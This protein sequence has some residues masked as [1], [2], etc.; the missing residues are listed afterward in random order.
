V[1][2]STFQ[3]IPGIGVKTERELWAKGTH[4]WND[5]LNS[6]KFPSNNKY[7]R[8][9]AGILESKG[10]LNEQDHQYFR[11]ILKPAITWRAYNEFKDDAC[12]VD[13]ETTGLSSEFDEITTICLHSQVDTKTFINGVNL[14]EFK[15]EYNKYKYVVTFNGA[16]FDIP[17]LERSLRFKSKH[18]HLDLLYPLARLGYRGGLKNIEKK[19]DINRDA[20]GITGFDA[21]R[22]WNAYIRDKK[23]DIIGRNLDGRAH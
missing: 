12:F 21:V 11:N 3:H 18:I 4:T 8:L 17:F 10:R 20:E 19:L 2:K 5:F 15:E 22:L 13:I 16:R 23:I 7:K 1:L 9:K 6:D 14:L